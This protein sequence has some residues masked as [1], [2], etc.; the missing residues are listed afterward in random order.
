MNPAEV[1]EH[2]RQLLQ[3]HPSPGVEPTSLAKVLASGQ[4]RSLRAGQALCAEGE[5]A[6]EMYFLLVG[7]IEVQ[8]TGSSGKP[9]SLATINAPAMVG[10]M[11]L[12]DNSKRSA[13]CVAATGVRVTLLDRAA[14]RTLL[15]QTGPEG[16]AL[17]RLLLVSLTQQLTQGNRRIVQLIHLTGQLRPAEDIEPLAPEVLDEDDIDEVTDILEGWTDLGPGRDEPS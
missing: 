9:R 4:P 7:Q 3:S 8:R 6:E 5:P 14:F 10:H 1:L 17:R 12:I 11:G 2:A 15:D 13:T 16:I